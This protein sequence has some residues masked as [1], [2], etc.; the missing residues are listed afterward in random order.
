MYTL[1]VIARI[2]IKFQKGIPVH[3]FLVRMDI[4]YYNIFQGFMDFYKNR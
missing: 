4:G 3:I 1:I 2:F